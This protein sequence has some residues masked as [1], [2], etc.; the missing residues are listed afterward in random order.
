MP[1]YFALAG[2][3]H[4]QMVKYLYMLGIPQLIRQVMQDL[5]QAK[6]AT[7]SA[8]TPFLFYSDADVYILVVRSSENKTFRMQETFTL[9]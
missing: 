7:L 1:C 3:T 5:T 2:H 4:T 6:S 8:L 9:N